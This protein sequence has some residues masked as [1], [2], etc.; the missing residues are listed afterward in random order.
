ML[1]EKKPFSAIKRTSGEIKRYRI[2]RRVIPVAIGVIVAFLAVLYVVSL[3]FN[4]FGSFTVTVANPDK[5]GYALSLSETDKFVRP[6]SR[7]NTDVMKEISNI[8]GR[9]LP[10]DVVDGSGEHSG[11]N[12]V[13]YTFYIKNSGS[14]ICSYDY[15]LI[16]SRATVGIDSAAR[17]RVYFNPYYYR[18]DTDEYAYDNSYVDYAKPRT[19]SGNAPEIDPDNRV[20]TN[21][22]S[23]GVV[24][25]GQ[26]DDFR[27]GDISRVTIVV[28]LEGNDPDCTDD[29]LGGELKFDMEINIVGASEQA[30]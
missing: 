23:P 1:G 27:P 19:G 29:V 30:A 20:M 2:Y 25:S 8:D 26:I 11:T 14:E 28:W 3:L 13:A 16:I 12:Y 5:R 6:T 15:N 18:A 9:T 21:F 7:L 10:Y 17:V 4:K 24:T 22:V